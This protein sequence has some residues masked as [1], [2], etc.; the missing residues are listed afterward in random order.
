MA[1]Y[2][3]KDGCSLYY[4]TIGFDFTRPVVIFLNGTMQTTVYWKAVASSLR[5]AFS[6]LIYDARGQGESDLGTLDLSLDLHLDDLLALIRHLGLGSTC[7]VGLSHGARLAYAMARKKPE[8]VARMV[9]CA[10]GL[11]SSMRARWIVRSWLTILE[12]AGLDALVRAALPHVFGERYLVRHQ[13]VLDRIAKTIVRRNRAIPLAA[14]LSAMVDYPNLRSMVRKLDLP[15]LVMSGADD[16]LVDTGGAAELASKSGGRHMVFKDAG[17]SIPV[18]NPELFVSTLSKFLSD[19]WTELP[20][21][22]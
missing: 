15:L 17:H 4:E 14:H 1:Y 6:S 2:K 16:V 8:S 12:E 7:L 19:R 22:F 10:I 5:P 11:R 21:G 18:E 13:K 20:E 9:L 3:T